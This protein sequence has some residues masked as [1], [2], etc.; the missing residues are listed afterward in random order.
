[1][2]R[3]NEENS[4]RIGKLPPGRVLKLSSIEP[5]REDQDGRTLLRACVLLELDDLESK[6]SATWRRLWP[7]QPPWRSLT[8][9]AHRI[10]E[11][12]REKEEAEAVALAHR[13]KMEAEQEE[14]ACQIQ[15]TY[16][17]RAGR[18]VVLLKRD[19]M[20]GLLIDAEFPDRSGWARYINHSRGPKRNCE[21]LALEGVKGAIDA[22]VHPLLDQCR[23]MYESKRWHEM[24]NHLDGVYASPAWEA[25]DATRTALVTL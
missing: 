5:P 17:G 20:A 12:R 21:L 14:A 11:A 25:S 22:A 2:S 1:M 18:K 9:R 13:R 24:T 19:E 10:S 6:D 8:W 3:S 4:E 16:R 15:A 7:Q 23:E